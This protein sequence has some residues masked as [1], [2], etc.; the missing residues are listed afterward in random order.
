MTHTDEVVAVK[1]IECEEEIEVDEYGEPEWDVQYWED[2]IQCLRCYQ[3][4]YPS[5]VYHYVPGVEVSHETAKI[6]MFYVYD[7]GF[8]DQWGDTE[9]YGVD[10][11]LSRTYHCSSGWRGHNET[12]PTGDW[13]EVK[14][15]W[16]TGD[17]GDWTANSKRDANQWMEDLITGEADCPV[18]VVIAFDPTS[19]VF[20]TAVGIW[21]RDEDAET[22]I[23]Y[24]GEALEGL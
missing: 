18:E 4:E 23:E 3:C 7:H 19:N 24:I 5:T 8:M 12:R 21:V 9:P 16:T 13:H 2:G 20:S 17:W 15:G 1:C 10:L 14:A 22:F 6:P 11:G